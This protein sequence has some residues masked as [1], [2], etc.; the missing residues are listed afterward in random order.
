MTDIEPIKKDATN[1]NGFSWEEMFWMAKAREQEARLSAVCLLRP[2]LTEICQKFADITNAR[3]VSSLS[4]EAE[5]RYYKINLKEGIQG[6]NAV[7]TDMDICQQEADGR[8]DRL[9]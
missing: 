4:S 2:D 1:K 3:A 9:K 8:L 6:I 5:K 7:T